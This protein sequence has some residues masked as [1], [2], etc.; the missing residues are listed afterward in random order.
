MPHVHVAGIDLHYDERGTGEPAVLLLHAMGG[1][2][3][4]MAP[5][6][7][8]LGQRWR[9]LAVDLR[10]HG[11]SAAPAGDYS[12][13]VLAD[14]V[15]ALA[16]ALGLDR[17]VVIGHSMG[18]VVA[19]ELAAR[20]PALPRA[21]AL[22]DAPIVTPPGLL[23]AFAPLGAA[24]RTPG[25]RE[26]LR[27]F[28]TAVGGFAD[29]PDRL[30]PVI[31]SIVHTPQHVLAASLDGV[32]TA[33]TEAAARACAVPLLYVGSGPWY[34]DVERLRALVPSLATAQTYGS[35]HFHTLE[36]PAQV[37]AILERFV[38][39]AAARPAV[40]ARAPDA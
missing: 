13:A 4:F 3:A 20:H 18:G 23:D 21:A 22:L 31:D 19:L 35:G 39:V 37:N 9:T 2:T 6:L 24:L 7:H 40:E 5:Q 8:H 34:T 30:A 27:A 12:A 1:S 32:L 15:A 26:A 16:R 28:Y 33:D 14:D 25:H 17:P 11:A 29:R 36:V 38:E 10:G